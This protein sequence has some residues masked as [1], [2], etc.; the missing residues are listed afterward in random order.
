MFNWTE[1]DIKL[2]ERMKEAV[3]KGYYLAGK[4]VTALHNRVMNTNLPTTNC[5]SCIRQRY[6]ALRKAYDV[7]HQNLLDEVIACEAEEVQ[8]PSEE[9]KEETVV[10]EQ[11]KATKTTSKTTVKRKI[12]K[13]T[14]KK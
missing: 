4:E 9:Q 10:E 1:E 7:Y 3:H 11:P 13:T 2:F 6:N 5:G 14:K 12:N 8:V